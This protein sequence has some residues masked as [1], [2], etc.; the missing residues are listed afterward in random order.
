MGEKISEN[1]AESGYFRVTFEFFYMQSI[2]DM[3]PTAILPLRRK[4]C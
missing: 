1:F 4:A 3:G 2:Y